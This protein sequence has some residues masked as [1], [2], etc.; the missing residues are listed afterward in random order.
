[1]EDR[2]SSDN[3][4]LVNDQ[5]FYRRIDHNDPKTPY[6]LKCILANENAGVMYEGVLS[7]NDRFSTHYF[8]APVFERN[9][10]GSKV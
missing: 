1:M 5:Y 3:K 6:G 9:P 7:R 8:P 10:D 2:P 4:A